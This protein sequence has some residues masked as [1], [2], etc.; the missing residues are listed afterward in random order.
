MNE[1]WWWGLAARG[2]W[3]DDFSMCPPSRGAAGL[4]WGHG[5]SGDAPPELGANPRVMGGQGVSGTEKW[6]ANVELGRG[7]DVG[8]CHGMD[9]GSQGPGCRTP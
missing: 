6:A 5:G 8:H 2:V 1:L 3:R 9:G 7:R 4:P